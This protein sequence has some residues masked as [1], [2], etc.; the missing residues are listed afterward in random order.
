MN[1]LMSFTV[2]V[3]LNFKFDTSLV[4]SAYR[5]C[6]D[7]VGWVE[8]RGMVGIAKSTDDSAMLLV[9]AAG[10]GDE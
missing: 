9:V 10:D 7:V 4:P 1:C 8:S 6:T 5:I 3:W 2:W